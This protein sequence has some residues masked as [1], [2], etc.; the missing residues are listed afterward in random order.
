M[1]SPHAIYLLLQS[2]QYPLHRLF[3]YVIPKSYHFPPENAIR[4]PWLYRNCFGSHDYLRACYCC[5][6]PMWLV[7]PSPHCAAAPWLL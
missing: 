1:S 7:V 5:G 4:G 6:V 2:G 3:G